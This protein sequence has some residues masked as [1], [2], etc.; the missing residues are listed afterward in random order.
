MRRLPRLGLVAV[1]MFCCLAGIANRA[2][3]QAAIPA[4]GSTVPQAAAPG[5]TIDVKLR[6]A[7]L[8]GPT[9]L[10]TSFPAE[11]QLPADI[12][13]NG[14]NVAELTYRVKLPSDA[15]LGV[16]GIRL[17]TAEGISGLKLFALDDL[18]SIGQVKPNQTV[19]TAQALTPPV[20][21]DG[22][23][24]NLSRDFYKFQAAAGQRLSIEVL[25]RR[26]GSPLDTMIRLLDARGRE[27]AYNDDAPGLG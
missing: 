18:P 17:V 16:H 5:Q 19:A 6:G 15:P 11:A 22:T 26:L 2:N 21:V 23:V 20:A 3:A 10:W 4:I 14:T 13:G 27:L 7:N 24:D 1:W 8:A 25:A 9:Q 12:A